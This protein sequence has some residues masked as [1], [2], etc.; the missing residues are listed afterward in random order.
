RK[1][2]NPRTGDPVEVGPKNVVTFQPGKEMEEQV[3]VMALVPEK[4]RKTRKKPVAAPAVPSTPSP[5][6]DGASVTA[7]PTEAPSGTTTGPSEN[8]NTNG[9]GGDHSLSDP[10]KKRKVKKEMAG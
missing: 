10:G 4:P 2:R 5:N 6:S 7:L 8:G 1:A 9:V 3:R